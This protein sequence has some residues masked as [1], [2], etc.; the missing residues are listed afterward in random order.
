MCVFVWVFSYNLNL[1]IKQLGLHI[2]LHNHL[3]IP[4]HS[5]HMFCIIVIKKKKDNRHRGKEE[6]CIMTLR[7]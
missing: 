1:Y 4:I 6:R 3:C 7:I 2:A 5:I